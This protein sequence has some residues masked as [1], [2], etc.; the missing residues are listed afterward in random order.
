MDTILAPSRALFKVPP[1]AAY[2]QGFSTPV[3]ID[4]DTAQ[5]AVQAIGRWWKKM[6]A[7]RYPAA[8]ELLIT[9]DGG[10]SNASRC[11]L[12]KVALQELALRLELPIHVCHFP[13]GTS[14]WNKIE[15]RMFCHITENWRGRPLVSRSVV[16]NLIGN[17]R[18]KAGLRINAELDTNS[19]PTGV[20]VTDE[21]LATVRI[22]KAKFHGEW[23]YT[24]SP[25]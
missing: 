22:K 17:T 6:G 1:L 7:K 16:V 11:R 19:Y 23:N 4:H 21:E 13:P 2:A 5:F 12:W 3:G 18:T 14:K 20:K 15:H 8:R 10:G 24:I 9:A 25:R